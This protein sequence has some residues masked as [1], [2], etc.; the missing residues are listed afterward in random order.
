MIDVVHCCRMHCTSTVA[1]RVRFEFVRYGSSTQAMA[2]LTRLCASFSP[3]AR[4]VRRGM[5][6]FV[7]GEVREARQDFDAAM[8]MDASLKP[9]L[10]Q[11]GL[12]LYYL[13]EFEEGAKQFRDDVD[14]NPNDTEE[15]IWTYLCESRLVGTEEAR[16]NFLHVGEDPRRVMRAA[17]GLFKTGKGIEVLREAGKREAQGHDDFYAKLYEGLFYESE[18]DES[19]AKEAILA[20]LETNYAQ[21]SGDYM[22]GLAQVHAKLRRWID[23]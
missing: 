9:R 16:R 22:A 10:W 21:R 18:G 6:R 1:K 4:L 8:A 7:R 17:Q 12:A 11:R 15:A 19:K 3:P 20:S 14:A 23:E 2:A 13:E 5:S